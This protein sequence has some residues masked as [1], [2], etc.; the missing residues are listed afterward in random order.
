M[1]NR[2]AFLDLY[3]CKIESSEGVDPIPTPLDDAMELSEH[4]DPAYGFAFVND[5]LDRVR[6]PIFTPGDPMIQAGK[7][8]EH[9][10]K[11]FFRG[12]TVAPTALAP[13]EQDAWFRAAGM[14]ATYDATV[15]DESVTYTPSDTNTESM[16]E[17]YYVDGKLYKA[18][19]IRGN[20]M[21]S[22]EAGGGLVT[23]FAA[24]GRGGAETDAAV[25]TTAVFETAE[26][27]IAIDAPTF[28]VDGFTTGI[29]RSFQFNLGNS[30][31]RRDNVKAIDGIQGYRI[32]RRN[33]Q[34]TIV[35]ED[36]LHSEKDFE[37]LRDNKTPV[38]LN[39]VLN[40]VQYN[41]VEF[42]AAR[43]FIR[44]V[45]PSNSDGL[46]ILTL[47][48]FLRSTVPCEIKIS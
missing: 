32:N 25:P 3:L 23:E 29:I 46:A 17:Y 41:T 27:P 8:A 20:L 21:L 6:G 7:T 12:T 42:T 2:N 38:A 26:W 30:I 39:W 45:Q 5:A 14:A 40:S 15:G 4:F 13:I 47:T 36:I 22:Y 10:L 31:Q 34:F 44:G 48:G 16:T 37:A 11:S 9:S 35:M 33:P 43:A 1:S 28:D 24:G 18:H 19:A